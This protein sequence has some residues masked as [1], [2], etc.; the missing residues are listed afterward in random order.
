MPLKMENLP[1]DRDRGFPYFFLTNYIMILRDFYHL[2]HRPRDRV[3]LTAIK[4][5]GNEKILE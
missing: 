4:R 1:S 3:L 5:S 2:A